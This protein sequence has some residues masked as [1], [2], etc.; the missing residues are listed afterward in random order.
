MGG[1]QTKEAKLKPKINAWEAVI[2][3][4]KS[5]VLQ[6]SI[7]IAVLGLDGAGKSRIAGLLKEEDKILTTASKRVPWVRVDKELGGSTLDLWI[8]SGVASLREYWTEVCNNAKGICYV[9]SK[10]DP[11][12]LPMIWS[13]MVSRL[14]SSDHKSPLL[15]LMTSNSPIQSLPLSAF[16]SFS[17]IIERK[18]SVKDID[19][20]LPT[21]DLNWQLEDAMQWLLG[22]TS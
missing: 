20:S 19:F 6:N 14:N 12:R 13:E 15:I 11:L 16:S 5:P 22:A 9:I 17:P 1:G 8:G 2:E 10:N 4:D 18:W 3:A 7:K 21:N